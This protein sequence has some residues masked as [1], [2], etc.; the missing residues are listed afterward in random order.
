MSGTKNMTFKSRMS[1]WIAGLYF[2]TLLALII[3]LISI[4]LFAP[5][6]IIQ[7]NVFIMSFLFF[8]LIIAIILYRAYQMRFIISNDNVIIHGLIKNHNIRQSD[9]QEIQK[10]PIPFG[11]RYFGASL[12]GGRYYYPGIG[13]AIV[14]MSNFDDGIL[15]KT[16]NEP[17]YVITPDNPS[18]FI[19][20]LNKKMKYA[21]SYV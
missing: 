3:M 18:R 11:F 8:I 4:P 15:I 1:K 12:L 13:K 7:R 19:E 6:T 16:N 10:I 17:Y 9:I 20:I 14:T 2:A 21:E 5:M